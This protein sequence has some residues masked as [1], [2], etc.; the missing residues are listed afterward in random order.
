MIDADRKGTVQRALKRRGGIIHFYFSMDSSSSLETAKANLVKAVVESK[1]RVKMII[2][3]RIVR[4]TAP[5]RAQAV[6]DVE[7]S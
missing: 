6:L 1:R 3:Q 5:Y 2:G 4:E 7:V